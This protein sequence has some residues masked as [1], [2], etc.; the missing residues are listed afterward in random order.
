[1]PGLLFEKFDQ[2]ATVTTRALNAL[3]LL[4]RSHDFQEGIL[5]FMAKRAPRFSG[6]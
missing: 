4:M 3:L 6:T 1:M 5:S 2:V